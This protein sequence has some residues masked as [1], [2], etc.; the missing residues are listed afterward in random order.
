MPLCI[1]ILKSASKNN[2]F[3]CNDYVEKCIA[4]LLRQAYMDG[5]R[6]KSGI[7]ISHTVLYIMI[8]F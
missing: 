4:Q 1:Y 8:S 2:I 7:S 6:V 5:R 3:Y